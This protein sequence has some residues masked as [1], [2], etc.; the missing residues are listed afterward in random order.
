MKQVNNELTHIRNLFKTG[1]ISLKQF[2]F[3]M[4]AAQLNIKLYTNDK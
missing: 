4:K 3:R 1:Q 2:Q